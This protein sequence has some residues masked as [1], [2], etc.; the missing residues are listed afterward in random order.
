M[1]SV[2]QAMPAQGAG[3]S[4]IAAVLKSSRSI[5]VGV[6]AISGLINLLM[7][8]GSLFMMQVYD[9]VLGSHSVPTLWALSGIAI[10]AYL[11]QGLLEMMRARVLALVGER[12]DDEAGPK[13]HQAV[14]EMPPGAT[15]G[16]AEA[17]QPF[18]DLDTVRAY[19]GGPGPLALFDMPWVPI[20][21]VAL[22]IL[23]PLLGEV[24][25]GSACVLIGL[26][27]L[28]D[29][30]GKGP[31]KAASEA[32]SKRNSIADAT[33]RNSEA[34]R[35]M[36]MH[37]VLSTRWQTAHTEAM[38]A[39]RQLTF[40]VG[41]I[42]SISK[43]F[44]YVLQSAMLGL[45]AYLA[46]KGEMSSGSIIAGTILSSRAL[47]PI[48]MAIGA[49]KSLI[50]ARQ[51]RA[52]LTQ[53]FTNFPARAKPFELP[54]PVKS[55]KIDNIIVTVPGT[56]QTIVKRASF[57]LEAGQGLGIIG[58]SASGKTSLARAIVGVWKPVSGR[59]ILDGAGLE[60]WDPVRLGPH[61]GY[62]PQDIQLFDGTIAENIARFQPDFTSKSVIAAA[63]ASGFH[64]TVLGFASGYDTRIGHGGA[65][66]SAGQRQRVGL[67]RALYGNP[68]LVV[69]DEPNSNLDSEGE[70][71][72]S[73]AIAS[74]RKRGGIVIVVAHR[75]SAIQAVDKLLVM[76]HGEVVAFG[77]RDEILA[78]TVQNA[79]KVVPI[80]PAA[81]QPGI[82]MG[83]PSGAPLRLAG[84]AMGAE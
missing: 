6:A 83:Q 49:W 75:P 33:Q 9:R 26:T 19:L 71:A 62:L 12:I 78:K 4:P 76:Q 54:A 35:A 70:G 66:L 32:T 5:F 56:P 14:I 29:F 10:G 27:V 68:F 40:A 59:I 50:A 72:V 30:R 65:Q 46:I 67:A 84:V 28:A 55:L 57:A 23:H 8:T 1:S 18:R 25:V 24:S 52:R 69:L 64:Q 80:N 44:R 13:I 21:V 17:M 39:N 16:S 81:G 43:T 2:T 63:T 53:L 20:Y 41:G 61:I 42:S 36:G 77:P 7:L 3:Q 34:V 11:F 48:D 60:Q 47:A 37:G 73:E 51:S 82:A 79:N 74:V 31:A 45:G 38:T 22:F 15:C 58:S